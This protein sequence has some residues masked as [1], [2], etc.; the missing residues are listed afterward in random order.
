MWASHYSVLL[1]SRRGRLAS[2]FEAKLGWMVGNIYSRVG[3]PDWLSQEDGE[4]TLTRMVDGALNPDPEIGPEWVEG[5][6]VRQ[7]KAENIV[8]DGLSAVEAAR[9]LRALV[10]MKPIDQIVAEV[11]LAIK[12]VFPELDTA[13]ISKI[14]HR[15]KNN[16]KIGAAIKQYAEESGG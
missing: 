7:A 12:A 4:R 6:L 1:S 11:E 15:V 16:S 14:L 3:V 10:T 13:G 8:L 5:R 2:E 9:R